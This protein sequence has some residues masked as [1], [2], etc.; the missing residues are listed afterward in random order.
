M[1]IISSCFCHNGE[2]HARVRHPT[3][4]VETGLRTGL[5][6][7]RMIFWILSWIL[8]TSQLPSVAG[9]KPTVTG[10][11]VFV[12]PFLSLIAQRLVFGTPAI[13]ILK[14]TQKFLSNF[15]RQYPSTWNLL[16][17]RNSLIGFKRC[18]NYPNGEIFCSPGLLWHDHMMINGVIIYN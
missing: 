17:H 14:T 1:R 11:N 13:I 10:N 9:K 15:W 12:S 2:W 18:S 16:H 3:V 7:L 6:L 5:P 4:K 8:L